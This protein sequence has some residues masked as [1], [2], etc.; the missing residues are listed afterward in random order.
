MLVIMYRVKGGLSSLG[1]RANTKRL[2]SGKMIAVIEVTAAVI[3]RGQEILI[4][5]RGE[6]QH[7]AGYWEFLGGKQDVT[8]P[9]QFSVCRKD[10]PRPD[11]HGSRDARRT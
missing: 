10:E 5:Q 7:L 4:T 2:A 1:L 9:N 6:G 11:S 3:K 8:K